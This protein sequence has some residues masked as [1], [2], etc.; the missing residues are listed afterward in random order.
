MIFFLNQNTIFRKKRKYCQLLKSEGFKHYNKGRNTYLRSFAL[1]G[2]MA[3]LGSTLEMQL[4]HTIWRQD[5][6][7]QF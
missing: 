7:G 6:E 1:E 3:S 2:E 5:V 4:R